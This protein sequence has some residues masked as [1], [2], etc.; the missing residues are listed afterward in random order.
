[1]VLLR[2]VREE[3]FEKILNWRNEPQVR[4]NSFNQKEISRNEHLDYW[5]KRIKSAEYDFIISHNGIDVGLLR[6]DKREEKAYEVNIMIDPKHQGLGIGS[7]AIKE[8]KKIAKAR[9]IKKLIGRVKHGNVGS[10]KI[11]EKNEF[12]L[13]Y[14]VYELDIE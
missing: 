9:G 5:H 10:N 11:F 4:K 8:I 7:D 3:D 14:V 1:M 6:L 12:Q 13:R 2:Q